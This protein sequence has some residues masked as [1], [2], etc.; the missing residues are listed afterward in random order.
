MEKLNRFVA[1]HHV[2]IYVIC[3]V[4]WIALYWLTL[5]YLMLLALV[6]VCGCIFLTA[7]WLGGRWLALLKKPMDILDNQ[8]DP[9]PYLE[10]LQRQKD[11]SGPWTLRY[12]RTICQAGA[13][14]MVGSPEEAYDLLLP[15]QKKLFQYQQP[16]VMQ[17]IYCN[18]MANTCRALD[19]AMEAE[20]WHAKYMELI[21]KVNNKRIQQVYAERMPLY[22]AHYHTFRKEY[23]L[24]MQSLQQLKPKN[25]YEQVVAAMVYAQNYRAIGETE[26]AKEALTF[27]ADNGN[28]LYIATRARQM[29]SEME[30]NTPA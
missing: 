13:L 12:N 20:Y 8:C 17:S 5:E 28:K 19:R 9:S 4:L 30:E 23:D 24:S 7:R 29:L 10:E 6:L 1:K 22:M 16:R 18:S 25:M 14:V 27:V 26:K 15:L 3:S 11:Y 21:A 2:P